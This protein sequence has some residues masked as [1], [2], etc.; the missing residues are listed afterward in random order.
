MVVDLARLDAAALRSRKAASGWMLTDGSKYV[1]A[2]GV[3]ARNADF[4]H[5]W[6]R[7]LARS[8]NLHEDAAWHRGLLVDEINAVA[9]AALEAPPTVLHSGARHRGDLA[10]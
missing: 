2:L 6:H 3:R 8:L 7:G 5:G 9:D 1:W 4:L 10:P